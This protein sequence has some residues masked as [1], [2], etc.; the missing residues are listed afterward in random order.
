MFMDVNHVHAEKG[1]KHSKVEGNI[2]LEID[3]YL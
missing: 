1:R 2:S 3:D